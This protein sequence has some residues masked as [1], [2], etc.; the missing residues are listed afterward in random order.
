[1]SIVSGEFE[2]L[3]RFVK[4]TC[5]LGFEPLLCSSGLFG[6]L[7]IAKDHISDISEAQSSRPQP[8]AGCAPEL[9]GCKSFVRGQ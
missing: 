6:S 2:Y 7:R 3:N 9:S 1:M 4:N 8:E 5:D